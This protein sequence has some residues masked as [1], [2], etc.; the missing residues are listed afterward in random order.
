M[1]NFFIIVLYVLYVIADCI[2]INIESPYV[3]VSG[4]KSSSSD[5]GEDEVTT[6]DWDSDENDHEEIIV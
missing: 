4:S 3:Y 6:D 2:N 5:I 1:F